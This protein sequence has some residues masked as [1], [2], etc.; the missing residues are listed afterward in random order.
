MAEPCQ[1]ATVLVVAADEVD[2]QF[3][4]EVLQAAGYVTREATTGDEALGIAEQQSVD[5]VVLGPGL[6]DEEKLTLR[7]GVRAHPGLHDTPIVHLG[8]GDVED[9]MVAE[10]IGE[11]TD[12]YLSHPPNER[13]F[14]ANVCALLRARQATRDL[15]QAREELAQQH[16]FLSAILSRLVSGIV[17]VE[18]PSGR[19][20][21][22]NPRVEK[23]WRRPPPTPGPAEEYTLWPAFHPGDGRPYEPEERPLARTL[24]TEE[25]VEG[26]EIDIL[27]GDGTRGTILTT[28]APIHDQEGRL[29]AAVVVFFDITERREAERERTELAETLNREVSHR[30]KNHLA[31]VA[32]LVHEQAASH[33]NLEIASVLDD[34]V[35]R[36]LAFASIHEQLQTFPGEEVDLLGALSHVVNALGSVSASDAT[37]ITLEG[38]A[39]VLPSQA[40]TNL[41]IVANELITNG[42]KYGG[43]D[44]EGVRRVE[45]RLTS[46]EDQLRLTVWNSGNPVPADFEVGQAANMGLR[47]AQGLV[48]QYGG[49]FSLR[50]HQ[51]GTLAEVTV[52]M[53]RLSRG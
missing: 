11:G 42:A 28:S 37:D 39:V 32:G 10:W 13:I 7:G 1:G 8:I 14:I 46:G 25:T 29:T 52:D 27:R 34:T 47:L 24:R 35:S 16:A 22:T 9:A 5:L 26:E 20:L 40:A 36:L 6:A 41:A 51:G 17:V 33:G 45:V 30:I 38:D 19:V 4:V 50:P 23:I 43:A 15:A 44:P 48:D 18:A 49:T 3:E 31:M 12:T 53:A 21:L 2:R